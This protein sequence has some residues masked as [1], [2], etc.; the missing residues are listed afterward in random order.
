MA[1]YR[2]TGYDPSQHNWRKG[3]DTTRSD[4]GYPK[5]YF[6]ANTLRSLIVGFGNFFNDLYVI[7]Y[8]EN[9][10]PVKQINVPLKYG[11]RMK[12]HD[13]RTEL[14][15]GEKY[16]IQYPNM[17]YRVTGLTF[18]EKRASGQ[19]ET[20]AFYTEYFDNEGI[21]SLL[22]EK[23]W[24]DTQP[25]PYNVNIEL[26]AKVEYM[27]DANQ[28]LEQILVRFA[29][30]CFIDLKEFWFM[31]KRRSIKIRHE[32]NSID[33]N[34]DFG[35]DQ[36]REITLKFTFVM[37]AYLYKNISETHIIDQILVKFVPSF[38]IN[39]KEDA[40]E[41][42]TE[43]NIKGNIDGSMDNRYDLDGEKRKSNNFK[44]GT[45]EVIYGDEFIK[46]APYVITSKDLKG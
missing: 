10:E 32:S 18:D 36:K 2:D 44:E 13:F 9:D 7:H 28:I 30:E 33:M 37:E 39:N 29:P 16:Y 43:V 27:S 19:L 34:Q 45:K 20:R 15:S 1:N 4:L 25:V 8:N 38:F 24:Q 11:P 31:N 17:T 42:G 26:E 35:E 21:P 46:N 22:S 14:E 23:F 6:F 40:I 41:E 12:S 5:N 3:E